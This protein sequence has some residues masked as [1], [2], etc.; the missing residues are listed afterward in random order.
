L[1]TALRASCAQQS[2]F[3]GL[4]GAELGEIGWSHSD[5]ERLVDDLDRE[6]VASEG[7]QRRFA[8]ASAAALPL[9]CAIAPQLLWFLMRPSLAA[10]LLADVVAVW[11]AF[12][13]SQTLPGVVAS[14]F[15]AFGHP[16]GWMSRASLVAIY[17]AL[18]GLMTLTFVVGGRRIASQ[19][20]GR[21][22]LRLPNREHWLAP[23]QRTA[24]LAWL[25]GWMY[26]MGTS[27]VVLMIAVMRLVAR[28]S[29]DPTLNPSGGFVRLL[30]G[31]FA[32]MAASLL[33]FFFRFSRVA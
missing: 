20:D 2:P 5:G 7:H 30:V 9:V 8:S 21:A 27:N 13:L 33:A 28:Y 11:H 23:E 15:D 18:V 16:N 22:K 31:F 26:L 10:L 19:A 24:T 6:V 4:L 17:L 3:V 1:H 25:S 12:E 32:F 29:A 14:H